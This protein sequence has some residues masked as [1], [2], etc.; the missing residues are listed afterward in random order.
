MRAGIPERVAMQMVGHKTRSISD[1][2]H[3]VSDGDLKEA[4]QRLNRAFS[5]Q[6]TTIS[7]TLDPFPEKSQ[8]SELAQV[9]PMQ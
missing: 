3:I 7:T 6:T 1:R 5:T 9:P 2:Y 4:A 8:S